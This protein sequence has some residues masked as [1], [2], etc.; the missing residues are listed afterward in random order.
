M[1]I[2]S[3]KSRVDLPESDGS[4]APGH[5]VSTSDNENFNLSHDFSSANF[6]NIQKMLNEAQDR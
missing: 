1:E 2:S 3:L 5:S 4:S 6:T